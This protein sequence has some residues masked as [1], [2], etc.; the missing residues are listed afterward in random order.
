MNDLCVEEVALI[1]LVNLMEING[2]STTLEGIDL[3]PWDSIT[4]NIKEWRRKK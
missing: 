4:W 1:P 2:V 3:T